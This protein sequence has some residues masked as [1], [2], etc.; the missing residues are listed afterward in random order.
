MRRSVFMCTPCFRHF[1]MGELSP[2]LNA[3]YPRE[4]AGK[5]SVDGVLSGYSAASDWAS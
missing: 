4:L 2:I 1:E 5:R 3:I